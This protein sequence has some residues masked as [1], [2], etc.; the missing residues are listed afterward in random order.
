[1]SVPSEVHTTPDD[2]SASQG[3]SSSLN[4]PA[5]RRQAIEI[6]FDYRGDVT[7]TLA[8]GEKL[9]GFLF[10]RDLE[11]WVPFVEMFLKG[12][13]QARR[14][15]LDE[16]VEIE[17]SGADPAAGRTWDAWMKKVAEAEASGKIAEL[18]PEETD[19]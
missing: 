8:S 16:L 6:A 19:E 7:L 4:S 18:Y 3:W 10:N 5:A 15:E 13:E 12:E 9:V 17:L 2:S 11:A 14:I 1:M